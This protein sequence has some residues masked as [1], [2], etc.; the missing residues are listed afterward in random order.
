M[1]HHRLGSWRC[2][3]GNDVDVD[4]V[5]EGSV[6]QIACFWDRFP[7]A[8]DDEAFYETAI[9]PAVVRRA[10]EYLELVGAALVVLA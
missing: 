8:P 9:L 1:R 5:G 3:S 2:P 7:L 4:L 6:R 10:Q